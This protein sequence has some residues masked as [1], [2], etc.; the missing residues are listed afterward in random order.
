MDSLL[1]I[2]LA[3]SGSDVDFY[4]SDASFVDGVFVNI[5]GIRFVAM[6]QEVFFNLQWEN[7]GAISK[8]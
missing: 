6:A 2:D 3:L 7:G 5:V 1:L 4:F 8:V